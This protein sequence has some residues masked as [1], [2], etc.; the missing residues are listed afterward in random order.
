MYIP[1]TVAIV[2]RDLKHQQEV[3]SKELH[4][5]YQDFDMVIAQAD[6]RPTEERLIAKALKQLIQDTGLPEVVFHSLRHLSTSMKLQVSGGDIKAVQ[7]DTGH[8]QATMVTNVYAHT[9]DENRK[10]IAD[11]M[12]SSFFEAAVPEKKDTNPEEKKV[13]ELLATNPEL[14]ALIL[15]MAK[16]TS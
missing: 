4:G 12:E 9:F 2:L 5:L 16:K 8:A 11:R 10:R 3:R 15:A 13:L 7:G 1:N 6:G 14:T